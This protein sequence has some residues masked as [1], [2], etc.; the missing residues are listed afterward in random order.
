MHKPNANYQYLAALVGMLNHSLVFEYFLNQF[1]WIT[2]KK[3]VS[4]MGGTYG[5]M[6]GLSSPLIV[7]LQSDHSPLPS[8]RISDNDASWITSL[9]ALGA[10]IG[11]AFFGM[12]AS[13]FGRK[14]PFIVLTIPLT[15]SWVLILCAESVFYI[16]VARFLHGVVTAGIFALAQLFFVEISNDKYK[17]PRKLK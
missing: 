9:K 8:G 11:F 16:F 1:Y 7:L 12:V 10:L 15:C 3:T 6:T 14:W 13:R 4:L 5:L 17:I 2:H